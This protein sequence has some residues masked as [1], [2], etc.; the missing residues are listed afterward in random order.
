MSVPRI[1]HVNITVA[2]PKRTA[3]LMQALFDWHIR[4]S[5]PAQNGGRIIAAG[6]KRVH[7]AALKLLAG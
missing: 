2:N 7:E 1:E 6:D 5:G 3:G 4:W